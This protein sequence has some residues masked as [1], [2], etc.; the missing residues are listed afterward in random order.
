MRRHM[1]DAMMFA[2]Q[3][4]VPVLEFLDPKWQT[5]VHM[6]PFV[7]LVTKGDEDNG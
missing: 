7:D 5:K 3:D 4:Y 6:G 2:R 1:M